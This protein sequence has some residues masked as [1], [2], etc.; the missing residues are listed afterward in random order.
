[1][2]CHFYAMCLC[3]PWMS[4]NNQHHVVLREQL[5]FIVKKKVR[6]K[7][8]AL[9]P[10]AWSP[11]IGHADR[12]AWRHYK[13]KS[14]RTYARVLWRDRAVAGPCRVC[15]RPPRRQPLWP[16]KGASSATKIEHQ[17][18]HCILALTRSCKD[19]Q[20]SKTE[21]CSSHRIYFSELWFLGWKAGTLAASLLGPSQGSMAQS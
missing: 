3:Q 4:Y 18:P 10:Q 11:K 16:F 9:N 7:A 5:G 14:L 17:Q 13:T 15:R 19:N 20:K 12:I 21:G 6:G 1:M 2:H 8:T